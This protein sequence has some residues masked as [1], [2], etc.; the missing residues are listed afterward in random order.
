MCARGRLS[1]DK[2]R[3]NHCIMSSATTCDLSGSLTDLDLC[4]T[5]D[6]LSTPP[7]GG[8]SDLIEFPHTTSEKFCPL[9]DSKSQRQSCGKQSFV[10]FIPKINS[11]V[12]GRESQGGLLPQP[13]GLFF[14]RLHRKFPRRP[15]QGS[16]ESQVPF[17]TPEETSC[18]AHTRT[19]YVS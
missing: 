15:P 11:F 6:V 12:P 18:V 1:G 19:L 9:K 3:N 14:M 4:Y 13:L 16:P 5:A 10:S 8:T 17:S 2:Q 7:I